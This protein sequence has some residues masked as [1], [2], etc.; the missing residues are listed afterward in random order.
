MRRVLAF[1]ALAFALIVFAVPVAADS[2]ITVTSDKFANNFP[3]NLSFQIEAQSST[4]RLTRAELLVQVE[5]VPSIARLSGAFAPG[6]MI[7]A[8][9]EW[10]LARDYLPPGVTGQYW[11]EIHDDAGNQLQSPPKTFRVEDQTHAWKQ[12][13]NQKLAVYWYAGS[14]NIVASSASDRVNFVGMIFA[15]VCA[16]VAFIGIVLAV[17]FRK[18]PVLVVVSV[19]IALG[20]CATPLMVFHS[21]GGTSSVSFGQVLFDHGVSS[22]EYLERDTGVTVDRQIQI[23]VYGDRDDFFNALEPGAKEWTGGRDFPE[24][25]VVLINIAPSDLE[26]GKRALAHEITH[27]VIHQKVRSPLSE[28]SLP[29]LIDEGLA[30]YY[31]SPGAPDPNG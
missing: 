3:R 22:L 12:A 10:N 13:S 27:Q 29:P 31:E 24:Y 30:V 15:A 6:T 17:I 14:D 11:W 5:G 1:L 7:R 4:T 23:Y 18:R 19:L 9:Y 20:A 25:G 21:V 16:L 2:P 8:T 26:W 28:L